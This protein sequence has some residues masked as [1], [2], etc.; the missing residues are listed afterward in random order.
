[1]AGKV[2]KSSFSRSQTFK[3][4][5]M[6][7][8]LLSGWTGFYPVAAFCE[9]VI[10]EGNIVILTK[11][12]SGKEIEARM[13]DIIQVELPMMGA[14]GYQWHVQDLDTDSLRLVSEE[15]RLLSEGRVGAPVMGI[16]KFEVRRE[17]SAEIRMEHYRA[18]E[19][20]ER[21]TDHFSVKLNVR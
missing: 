3:R 4:S 19:G 9:G 16:W 17:G 2:L 8:F 11:Q 1:M 20:V 5:L 7:V 18:W 10:K 12:D 14:A 15:T 6:I 21:S 13:G